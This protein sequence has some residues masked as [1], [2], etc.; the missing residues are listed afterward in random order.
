M[1]RGEHMM[2]RQRMDYLESVSGKIIY[3]PNG[4]NGNRLPA[5][6]IGFDLQYFKPKRVIE[7]ELEYERNRKKGQAPL[8]WDGDMYRG[9]NVLYLADGSITNTW[10]KGKDEDRVFMDIDTLTR[11]QGAMFEPLFEK[12]LAYKK[13]QEVAQEE[14]K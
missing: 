1:V 10:V 14:V 13:S 7:R 8:S 3:Q 4:I 5:I 2:R 6:V 12:L 11:R 9:W